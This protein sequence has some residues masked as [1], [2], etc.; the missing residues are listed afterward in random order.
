MNKKCI[1]IARMKGISLALL[2]IGFVFIS[3]LSSAQVINWVALPPYETLWPL[4]SP[5]LSPIDPVSGDPTPIVSDLFP[6]TVLPSQPGLTWDP[7]WSNPWLLY[8]TPA[9]LLFYDP[10]YGIN[11]WPPDYLVDPVTGKPLPISL[12]SDYDYLPPTSSSWILNTVPIANSSYLTAYSA[13]APPAPLPVPLAL[14]LSLLSAGV[15]PAVPTI[16]ALPPPST[17]LLGPAAILGT[18]LI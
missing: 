2:V 15:A 3:S 14:L 11:P 18:A 7:A 6:T 13:Y 12:P 9:G 8:N 17:S 4:W 10:L 5:A 16:P 1:V